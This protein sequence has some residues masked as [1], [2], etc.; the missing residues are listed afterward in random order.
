ML[1]YFIITIVPMLLLSQPNIDWFE[2][3]N[4]SSEESHGHY[5]LTCEDGGF[6]QIGESNFLPNSKI[7]IVKIDMNADNS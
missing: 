7:F 1:K 4:G 6:L 5:I 3:Y 2:D